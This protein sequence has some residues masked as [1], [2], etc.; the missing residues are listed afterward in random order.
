MPLS[1]RIPADI[2]PI[3]TQP[4]LNFEPFR[5][6]HS[7]IPTARKLKN[8]CSSAHSYTPDVTQTALA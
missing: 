2:K 8:S 6:M 7:A 5:R 1:E 4:S 3:H